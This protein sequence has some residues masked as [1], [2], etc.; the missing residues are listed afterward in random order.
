MALQVQDLSDL[1]DEEVAQFFALSVQLVQERFPNIDMRRGVVSDLVVGLD[2]ILGAAQAE[3]TDLVRQSQSIILIEAN[4]ELADDDLVDNVAS[5]YRVI[6]QAATF[7]AGEVVIVMDQALA[8]SVGKGQTFTVGDHIYTADETYS[9]RL[10]EAQVTADTDRLLVQI[11][12]DRWA[13]TINVTAVVAGS[14]SLLRKDDELIPTLPV[15]SFVRAYAALDFTGGLDAQTNADLVALLED[16]MSTKAYSNRAMIRDM[17]RN[18][19]PDVYAPV[20]DAFADILAMGI[21]GYGDVEQTRDQHW[22]FPVSGGGRSDMYL[23]S[24]RLPATVTM[25]K[26]ATLV[27]ETVNGGI[28]QVSIGRNDAPG[29]YEVTNIR[30]AG[31]EAD[32]TNYAVQLDVRGMDLTAVGE[33]PY[34]PDVQTPL[35]ATYSR[36]QT[37]VI[38]FLDPDTFTAGLV[39]G[40]ATQDYDVTVETDPLVKQVQ[41]FLGLR[42]VRNPVGDHLVK[43]AIPCF[44]SLSIVIERSNA[45]DEVDVDAITD[46]VTDYVNTTGFPG[47]LYATA[48]A[49]VI[50]P[51]LPLSGGTDVINMLGRIRNPDGTNTVLQSAEVLTVPDDAENFVSSRTVVFILDPNDVAIT[52]NNIVIA[53][54]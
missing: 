41:E 50:E 37:A 21:T 43:G 48:I 27:E 17:V 46:A 35:E 38:Q 30:P 12:E 28:W 49:S 13:F 34:V 20:T 18:A 25:D 4:P 51:L 2:A 32:G 14:A 24:Q 36:Y 42:D 31:S 39:V 44:T 15:A 22:L 5:N 26:T 11:G 7:A 8:V 47:K 40:V 52:I 16:G 19:D 54:A 29:F 9:A 6:R 23:R 3:N 10:T 33:E 45:S 53:E 1:S